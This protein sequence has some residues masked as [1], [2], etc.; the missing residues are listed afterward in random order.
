MVLILSP[1]GFSQV[2]SR[3]PLTP[4]KRYTLP[5]KSPAT[6]SLMP[7]PVQSAIRST[8]QHQSLVGPLQIVAPVAPFKTLI[9]EVVL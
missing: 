3:F 9:P 7:S 4:S 5:S 6:T 1:V 8:A 2:H